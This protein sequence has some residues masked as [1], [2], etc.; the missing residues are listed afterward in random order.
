M[1]GTSIYTLPASLAATVGPLGIVAWV[2][3]AIGYLG[4]ALVYASLGTRYPR[5]GGPYV[6]AREAFGDFAGF[7]TVWLYWISAVLGN[8]GITIGVIAY[9]EGFIPALA[10]NV[11]LKFVVAQT[12]LWGLCWLNIRGVKQSARVQI[13]IMLMNIVPLLGLTLFSL[14]A[15]DWANLHPF[16]PK[17]WSSLAAG[18]A[19]IVWAYSGVE[20]ATVP[21]EEVRSPERMI[22]RG[23][24]I[25]Y[26]I[27]TVV[28]LLTSIVVA[29]VLPNAVVAS[30]ARPIALT[31]GRGV[32]PWAAVVI[33]V[34][35]VVAGTGTLNGWILMSGRIPLSAANDGLFFPAL[36]R[37][38]PRFHTPHVA[39][40][41]G[42]AVASAALCLIFNHT[43]LD[44]FDFIV[45]LTVWLTLVP[46]LFAAAA[47]LALARRDPERYTEAQRRRAYVFG[48]LAFVAVMYFIY[49]SGA[50]VGRWGFLV[51]VGGTP[52]YVWFVSRPRRPAAAPT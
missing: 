32:G 46:H 52:L 30:S 48:S 37:I 27:G 39:L 23:T 43:L 1:V 6:Y 47:E 5:T 21:A 50:E 3:T 42:T 16:A 12:M 38:H 34:G 40:V 18:T 2:L 13:A 26:A 17:G 49:G 44:A 33:S 11:P 36:A 14:R 35:A 31:V 41:A 25:G 15:F 22:S 8:A 51:M 29:G 7:Q 45:L 10:A 9:V 4:V 24:M 20:S 28:F 19:L